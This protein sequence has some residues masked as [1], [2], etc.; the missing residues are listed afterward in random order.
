FN[1]RFKERFTPYRGLHQLIFNNPYL[2]ILST[3]GI[4]QILFHVTKMTKRH[5]F[6]CADFILLPATL[7]VLAGLFLIPVPYAQYYLLFLPLCALFASAYL[8]EAVDNLGKMQ[9]DIDWRE[10]ISW[11]SPYCIAV[12]LFLGLICLSVGSDHPLIVTAY[13]FSAFVGAAVLLRLKTPTFA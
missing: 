12:F 8:I 5:S 4:I 11:V 3:L 10:W 13:W 1:L 6:D 7:G 9:D 2:A